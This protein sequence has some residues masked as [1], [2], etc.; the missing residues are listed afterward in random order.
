MNKYSNLLQKFAE[1]VL[2]L[3]VTLPFLVPVHF[4]LLPTFWSEWLALFLGAM[5]VGLLGLSR[6]RAVHAL[7]PGMHLPLPSWL[8]LLGAIYAWLQPEWVVVPYA[9]HAELFAWYLCLAAALVWAGGVMREQMGLERL[10][11]LTARAILVGALMMASTGLMQWLGWSAQLAPWVVDGTSAGRVTGNLAQ[12][13]L[14]ANYLVLGM[15]SALYLWRAGALGLRQFVPCL[16]FLVG[17]LELATS[18]AAL[19]MLGALLVFV[20]VWWWRSNKFSSSSCAAGG[21]LLRGW[22]IAILAMASLVLLAGPVVAEL[23]AFWPGAIGERGGSVSRVLE[24]SNVNSGHMARLLFWDK[25]WSMFLS[26]PLSGVGLGGFSWNFY[27][28]DPLWITTPLHGTENN[29]HNVFMHLLAETGLPG[30]FWLLS[31]PV[32]L[33]VALRKHAMQRQGGVV[34]GS[35]GKQVGN[36]FGEDNAVVWIVLVLLAEALHSM[37]EFPLWH[38]FFLCLLAFVAGLLYP[39]P[40]KSSTKPAVVGLMPTQRTAKWLNDDRLGGGRLW[41]AVALGFSAAAIALLALHGKTF[42]EFHRVASISRGL[43]VDVVG[44]SEVREMRRSLLVPFVD[45]GLA[46]AIPLDGKDL[47]IKLSFSE[48]VVHYWPTA[49][50]VHRHIVLLAQAGR[51]AEA[52]ALLARVRKMVPDS[53]PELR[54]LVESIPTDPLADISRLRAALRAVAQ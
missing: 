35:A 6:Y 31:F 42:W 9:E 10:A 54:L 8:F 21:A 14:Y 44:P 24:I 45:I 13:N 18:R 40:A 28:I 12:P 37:V 26:A 30:A 20:L 43:Q 22:F 39:P 50:L 4:W 33:V 41:P 15:L 7:T 5:L 52:L 29:A 27:N 16:I 48:K 1:Q 2:T 23:R 38:A 51:D 36:S 34:D 19:F 46:L 49:A 3:M 17:M 53:I 47:P 32:A 25:A 11:V